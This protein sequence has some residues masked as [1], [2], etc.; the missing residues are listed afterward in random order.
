MTFIPDFDLDDALRTLDAAS[1][2][3]PAGS[4]EEATIQLAAI[5][6]LYV[7]RT[8]KLRDFRKYY[9]EFF[10][11][12]HKVKVSHEFKTREEA[13]EWLSSGQATDGELVSIAGQGFQVIQ[14]PKGLKFLRTP[15]P[16]ELGPP[17]SE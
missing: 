8:G 6:M 13:D 5:S 4:K 3:Y 1:K 2:K 10:D 7:L 16:E 14:L 11:P 15:L 17:V 9:Q 12:S